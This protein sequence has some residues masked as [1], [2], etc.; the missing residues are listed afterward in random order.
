MDEPKERIT[1][2]LEDPTFGAEFHDLFGTLSEAII[3]YGTWERENERITS[4]GG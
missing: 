3:A 1:A 4:Y 2:K